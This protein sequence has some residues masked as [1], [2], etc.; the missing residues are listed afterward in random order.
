MKKILA[1]LFSTVLVVGLF[2]SI[3]TNTLAASNVDPFGVV[4]AE[5]A[6][7]IIGGGAGCSPYFK[8]CGFDLDRNG[9]AEFQNV[10]FAEGAS[11][12]SFS[13]YVHALCEVSVKVDSP[14]SEAIGSIILYSNYSFDTYT[15]NL[16]TPLTGVHNFYF[17]IT[18]SSSTY[19]LSMD[20][21][22][23]EKAPE[24]PA[25]T[26]EYSINDWG[27]G[28]QVNFNVVN[29]TDEDIVGWALKIKKS[30]CQIDQSWCVNVSQE[31]DYY[32]FTPMSWNSTLANGQ[33]TEFGM[34]GR[35]QVGSTINYTVE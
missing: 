2:F 33:S 22:S 11:S 21:W 27:S 29:N 16:D 28:Y 4:E 20:Y 32:V 24:A 7:V 35:G 31:G 19:A 8:I 12:I 23:A 30:D 15:I 18:N 17:V 34:I 9:Y 1:R 13:A 26:L 25:L 5:N 6:D 14:D 3:N 10:D